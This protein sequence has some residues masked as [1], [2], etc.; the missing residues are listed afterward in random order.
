MKKHVFLTSLFAISI[1]CAANAA[2]DVTF[3]GNYTKEDGETIANVSDPLADT[4]YSYE[5]SDGSTVSDVAYGTNPD[6][7]KFTYTDK[8]GGTADFSTGIPEQSDFTGTSTAT[9]DVT[10]TQEIVAGATID[11]N[12]YS[13]KNGNGDTVTLGETAQNMVTEQTLS[14][15]AGGIVVTTTNGSA[16]ING[17]DV[18][19]LD[20]GMYTAALSTGT[21]Y[22]LSPDGSQLLN[23]D[24]AVQTPDA[25]SC[26]SNTDSP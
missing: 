25:G 2:T 11:R 1:S 8:D 12:N 4:T 17:E 19:S 24:G 5:A 22:K 10:T 26:R 9:G 16:Q 18:T 21:Q 3:A 23:M 14:A 15:S 13:Y 6:M 20:G 7:T